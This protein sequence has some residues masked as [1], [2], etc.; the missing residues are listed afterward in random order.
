MT[1]LGSIQVTSAVLSC[2]ADYRAVPELNQARTLESFNSS[3]EGR[4]VIAPEMRFDCHGYVTNW[5][6]HTL[7]LT[8]LNYVELL[9]HTITFQVWRP[10][11]A[12]HSYALVGS[13]QLNF[14]GAELRNGITRILG[15]ADVA[16]FRLSREVPESERI[17]VIP[18]DMIGWF[19]ATRSATKKPLSVLYSKSIYQDDPDSLVT[20]YSHSSAREACEMCSREGVPGGVGEEEEEVE[21]S[22]LPFIAPGYGESYMYIHVLQLCRTLCVIHVEQ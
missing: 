19:I 5:T 13:N 11:S 7:V 3:E 9:T 2:S 16:Y 12:G 4:Q 20:L 6:A 22:V 17:H 14:A 18:G 10:D 1:V 21:T 8:S 15:V